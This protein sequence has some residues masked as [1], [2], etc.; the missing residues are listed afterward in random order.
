MKKHEK[1]IHK[2][3]PADLLYCSDSNCNYKTF[4]SGHLNQHVIAIHKRDPADV[5]K[6]PEPDCTYETFYPEHLNRHIKHNAHWYSQEQASS[7][8]EQCKEIP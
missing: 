5:K 2:R 4:Y 6:C 1:S 3:D 8:E 7:W